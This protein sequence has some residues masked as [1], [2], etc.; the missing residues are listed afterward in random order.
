MGI[1]KILLNG[2]LKENPILILM[3]GLCPVLAC[4]VSLSDAF[5]MG[6]AASFV[7]ISSN[8][9]ISCF[10]KFIPNQIRIPIFIIIIATFVIIVDYTMKAYSPSLSKSLGV[11]VPLIVVNCIILA[12][13]E[14]FACKNKVIHSIFDGIGMSLGFTV[15]ICLVGAIREIFG[16]GTILGLEILN[17]PAIMMI[18][19]PGG[20]LVMGLLISIIRYF[21]RRFGEKRKTEVIPCDTCPLAKNCY[22]K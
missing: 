21:E 11:F 1:L 7:L 14:A 10:R 15:V 4:S 16:N 20:F 18:L 3:I 9:I 22:R 17:N 13:A 2:L 5:G 12:R 6:L 19:P 8:F